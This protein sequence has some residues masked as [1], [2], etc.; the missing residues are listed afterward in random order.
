[1]KS[2]WACGGS[3]EGGGHSL[4]TVPFYTREFSPE[5]YDHLIRYVNGR[6]DG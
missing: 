6:V 2:D 1:M 4:G 3:D 5:F